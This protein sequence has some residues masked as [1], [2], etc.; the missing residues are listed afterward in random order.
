MF[1]VIVNTYTVI[2]GSAAGL[3]FKR[4]IPPRISQTIIFSIG[5]CSAMI[6]VR[7]CVESGGSLVLVLSL[8]TGTAMG[9]DLDIQGKLRHRGEM[10]GKEGENAQVFLS[11]G[12]VSACLMFCVG[13]MTITGALNAGLNHDNSMLYTKSL[14][15]LICSCM[16]AVSLGRGVLLSAGFVLVF[17]GAL[18]LLAGTLAPVLTG[19]MVAEITGVGSA[20]IIAL[21]LNVLGF[22]KLHVANFLPAVLFAPFFCWAI[23]LLPAGF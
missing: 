20:L 3:L 22:E 2:R 1:G 12:F 15:D 14:M 17:E 7:G 5:L 6:G 18:V 13:A 19:P 23:S 4:G 21:G 8:V 16:L 9:A 11:E 10:F